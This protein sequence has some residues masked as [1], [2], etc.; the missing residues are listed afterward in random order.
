MFKDGARGRDR[1]DDPRFTKESQPQPEPAHG[2]QSTQGEAGAHEL[3]RPARRPVRTYFIAT[4]GAPYFKVGIALEP[5]KRLGEIQVGCPLLCVLVASVPG[6]HEDYLHHE[7]RAHHV[8]GEW[9]K[10]THAARKRL[11]EIAFLAGLSDAIDA[12]CFPVL[13]R[14]PSFMDR[15]KRKAKYRL[16]LSGT[17]PARAAA[18]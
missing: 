18:K 5:E 16:D 14:P 3:R 7:L 12:A 13:T 15:P 1:T 2:A 4:S 10:F 6:D 9:F 8:R 11:D 17:S